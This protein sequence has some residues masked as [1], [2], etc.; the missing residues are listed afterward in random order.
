MALRDLIDVEAFERT[1]RNAV[2]RLLDERNEQGWW[3]GELSS[4]ALS[5]AT[6]VTA[7]ALVDRM[8][9]ETVH[10]ERVAR[11][12][13]WLASQ[14]NDDGGWGDTDKSFSN[15]STTTLVWAAFSAAGV[16]GDA[17]YA[18]V[19]DR[20]E[21]RLNAWVGEYLNGEDE[22]VQGG[23]LS[24][25]RREGR[26][27]D[28]V[29]EGEGSTVDVGLLAEAVA[30]RYGADRTFSVPIL[31]MCALSGRL[32]DVRDRATW[33]KITPLPFELAACPRRLYAMLNLRVVS[34]AL[35]ALIAI[36]QVRHHFAPTR[37]PVTRVLRNALRKRTLKLLEQIQ[38]SN[39]GFLEATPL[40]SFVTMS[41]AAMGGALDVKNDKTPT[42]SNPWAPPESPA[43]RVTERG[44]SFL[45]D[46]MR[47]DGSWPID[48]NLATWVTTLSVNALAAGPRK[49]DEVLSEDERA[50]IRDWLLDQQYNEV[51]PYTG[52]APGGWAWTDLPGGVPDADDTSGAVLAL[53]NLDMSGLQVADSVAGG[54]KWLRTVQNRN[55][56]IP[57][58][59]KGWGRLPFDR[60]S[61]DITAHFL[62]A[63]VAA[64]RVI[65]P[66]EAKESD[67]IRREKGVE[68]WVRW[69]AGRPATKDSVT[70]LKAH[71]FLETQQIADGSI[72]PLWFGCQDAPDEV[73]RTYGTARVVPHLEDDDLM[74]SH[75]AR[76]AAVDWLI[77]AQNANGGWGGGLRTQP[78]IEETALAIDALVLAD[79]GLN[80]GFR[81]GA[82]RRELHESIVRGVAWL[83]EHT[84]EGT[85][86]DPA[87]IGFY[88][89]K[90]WYYE[91]LYPIIFAVGALQ[92]VAGVLEGELCD[93]EQSETE[94]EGGPSAAPLNADR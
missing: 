2:Q 30:A 49:L 76:S 79:G 41:L 89:A 15:I 4:S 84:R 25:K 50:V 36:G 8:R 38:P 39:G 9:G 83:I 77:R 37:N 54:L 75:E 16:E 64:W 33:A 47:D 73:N 80:L 44:V 74:Y 57:T 13:D 86:F 26:G 61:A 90:L 19:M 92:R 5:T 82:A 85:H 55:G 56:G 70:N 34:Y 23:A 59:C 58:F 11:G 22:G 27:R 63:G 7:L 29:V 21:G 72:A 93:V 87:P 1:R 32:G 88:F 6:A 91:K 48:T 53:C 12:I 40:T 31:T 81:R 14:Q 69:F 45:V 10:A 62:A 46:S 65:H 51:H 28:G 71:R 66:D 20:C 67:R 3:T 24:R 78:S 17:R 68:A 43:A 35:P 18:E 42:D 60:S 52:A 94:E